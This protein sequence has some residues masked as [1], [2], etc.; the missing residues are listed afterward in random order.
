MQNLDPE[1]KT[2]LEKLLH[3]NQTVFATSKLDVGKFKEFVVL[4]N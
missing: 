3:D 4:K 1:I 2:E